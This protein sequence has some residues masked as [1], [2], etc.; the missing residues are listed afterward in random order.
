MTDVNNSFPNLKYLKEPCNP[1]D[2]NYSFD[3]ISTNEQLTMLENLKPFN[4]NT[5][6]VNK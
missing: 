5:V 3:V 6:I 4:S 1:Y 2:K